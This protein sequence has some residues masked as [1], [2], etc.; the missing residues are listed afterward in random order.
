MQKGLPSRLSNF[1]ECLKEADRM[2]LGFE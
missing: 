2:I 1:V